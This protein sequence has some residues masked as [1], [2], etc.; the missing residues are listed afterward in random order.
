MSYFFS[1]NFS[2]KNIYLFLLTFPLYYCIEKMNIF[3]VKS[4]QTG[5]ASYFW[6]CYRKIGLIYFN[7]WEHYCHFFVVNDFIKNKN[8]IVRPKFI[9]KE[10][11]YDK[12][13]HTKTKNKFESFFFRILNWPK[14]FRIPF[15]TVDCFSRCKKC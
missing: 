14:K 10:I 6:K 12:I 13:S 2:A 9:V 4:V 3:P 8:K 7:Q 15:M 5:V 1:Q 11:W